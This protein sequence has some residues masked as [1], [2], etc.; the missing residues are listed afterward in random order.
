MEAYREKYPENWIPRCA[1]A[2]IGDRPESCIIASSN[3]IGYGRK[4]DEVLDKYENRSSKVGK[5]SKVVR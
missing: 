5:S 2:D 3:H 1:T 4:D